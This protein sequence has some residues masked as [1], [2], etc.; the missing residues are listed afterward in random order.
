MPLSRGIQSED[1]ATSD[2][3]SEAVLQPIRMGV[4]NNKVENKELT[5]LAL[6]YNQNGVHKLLIF[7]FLFLLLIRIAN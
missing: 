7:Q 4:E 5:P 2:C 6:G 1:T 3:V